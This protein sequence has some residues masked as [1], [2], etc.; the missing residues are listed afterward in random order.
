MESDAALLV[1]LQEADESGGIFS[2]PR[3]KAKN[4][5]RQGC[6]MEAKVSFVEHWS[7]QERSVVHVSW[8][9]VPEGFGECHLPVCGEVDQVGQGM[10]DQL[11]CGD[12]EGWIG[13]GKFTGRWRGL[14]LRCRGS[15]NLLKKTTQ[16]VAKSWVRLF[17]CAA[18]ASFWTW[19]KMRRMQERAGWSLGAVLF[20]WRIAAVPRAIARQAMV[21][22]QKR[23]AR[24]IQTCVDFGKVRFDCP[25]DQSLKREDPQQPVQIRN[26]F[27][28]H[29]QIQNQGKPGKFV[30]TLDSGTVAG[31][32][33]RPAMAHVVEI[34]N[35]GKT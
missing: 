17:K 33:H 35:A 23:Q 30:V 3:G 11:D 29:V 27:G 12:P 5:D 9:G 28:Q 26:L 14:A 24:R 1:V 16:G 10:L 25:R 8:W 7:A 18:S 20:N 6:A 2:W 15:L 22:G 21:G 13:R 4:I 19:G 34:W 31:G 32:G